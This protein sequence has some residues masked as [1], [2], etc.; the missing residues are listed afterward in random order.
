MLSRRIFNMTLP[1]IA[2]LG[3]SPSY[4]ETFDPP[5]GDPILTISGRISRTN[6]GDRAMFDRDMLEALGVTSFKTNTP[7]YSSAVTFEGV[8]MTTLMDHVQAKGEL[9]MVTALN[10][11]TS[12]IPIED[13]VRYE[14]ILALKR[15]GKYMAISDKGPLFIVYP[16]DKV[17]ELRSQRFYSRSAW[18]IARMEV[19]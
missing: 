10:D 2:I 7:W 9:L 1:G 13:F 17:P 18:Q 8:K 12:D 16:Y 14:P 19:R 11:Y 15:D 5:A 3:G 4:A 6:S